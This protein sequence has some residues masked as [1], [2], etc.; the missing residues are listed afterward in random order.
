MTEP[1]SEK[2]A[3]LIGLGAAVAATCPPCLSYHLRR[4]REAG[5]DPSEIQ[6]A[7]VIGQATRDTPARIVDRLADRLVGTGLAATTTLATGCESEPVAD[8][9]GSVTTA[10]GCCR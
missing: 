6:A 7:L 8:M 3:E 10:R 2:V 4:A 5:A 1:L 9:D